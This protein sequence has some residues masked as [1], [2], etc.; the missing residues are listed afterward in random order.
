MIWFA[1]GI[2]IGSGVLVRNDYRLRIHNLPYASN[3][4]LVFGGVV[5]IRSGSHICQY[6]A[7]ENTGDTI[8]DGRMPQMSV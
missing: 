2:R 4:T 6:F 7:V 8:V 3:P 5:C 1:K